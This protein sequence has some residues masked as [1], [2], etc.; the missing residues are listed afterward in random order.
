MTKLMS[1]THMC[2]M[3]SSYWCRVTVVRLVS[4]F[5]GRCGPT[6]FWH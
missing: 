5:G 3:S 6:L 1:C 4:E 2:A